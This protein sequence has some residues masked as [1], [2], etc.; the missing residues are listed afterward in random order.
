MGGWSW[1]WSWSFRPAHRRGRTP[2]LRSTREALSGFGRRLFATASAG[3]H[4]IRRGNRRQ[5]APNRWQLALARQC[6]RRRATNG[7]G[8]F[9]QS[10]PAAPATPSSSLPFTPIHVFKFVFQLVQFIGCGSGLQTGTNWGGGGGRCP[11]RREIRGAETGGLGRF[12][13]WTQSVA[14]P[15][16]CG[17]AFIY[18]AHGGTHCPIECGGVLKG[19]ISTLVSSLRPFG[20]KDS[21][22]AQHCADLGGHS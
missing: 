17:D 7:Q 12:C 16:G 1:C 13:T 8:C 21:C 3:S 15:Q 14:H 22:L 19:P 9:L 6:S 11:E 10:A 4:M 20:A 2:C 18:S 5:R